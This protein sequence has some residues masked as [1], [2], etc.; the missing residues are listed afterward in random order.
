MKEYFKDAYENPTGKLFFIICDHSPF[1]QNP[2]LELKSI[3]P[4]K[5]DLFDFSNL[6]FYKYNNTSSGKC[7]PCFKYKN[8]DMEK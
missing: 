8:S 5:L 7:F 3:D 2:Q 4:D 1:P 6:E